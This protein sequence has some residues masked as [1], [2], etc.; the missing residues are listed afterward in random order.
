M[1]SKKMRVCKRSGKKWK[2]KKKKTT[3]VR[4]LYTIMTVIKARKWMI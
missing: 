2:K 3:I 4:R 1:Q